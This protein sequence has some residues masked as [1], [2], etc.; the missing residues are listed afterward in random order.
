MKTL[1]I[2]TDFNNWKTIHNF[3]NPD[4]PIKSWVNETNF[5]NH[6]RESWDE[7]MPV[8]KKLDSWA[9]EKMTFEEFDNYRTSQWKMIYNPSKYDIEDVCNQ[10]AQFIHHYISNKEN[11]DED[12]LSSLMY[13]VDNNQ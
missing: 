10:A 9:N 13:G 11:P 4:E 3:I 12:H 6:Y 7:L 2:E 5:T 1:N 8:I